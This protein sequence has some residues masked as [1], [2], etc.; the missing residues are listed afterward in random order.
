MPDVNSVFAGRDGR[1]S[2]LRVFLLNFPFLG[3]CSGRPRAKP[4][5]AIPT[6]LIAQS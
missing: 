1:S 5:A 2:R 3:V 6:V 4:V